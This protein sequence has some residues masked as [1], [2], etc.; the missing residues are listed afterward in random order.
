MRESAGGYTL[1]F[2]LLRA[3]HTRLFPQASVEGGYDP[4]EP[5]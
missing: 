4:S 1:V 3:C 5:L 2:A